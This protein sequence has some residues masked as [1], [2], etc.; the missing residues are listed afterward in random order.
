MISKFIK[1][2]ITAP[3]DYSKSALIIDLQFGCVGLMED[4][5]AAKEY[6]KEMA[7]FINGL[8]EQSIP[9]CWATI[10]DQNKLYKP[11]TN[12]PNQTIR[13][14][15]ELEK[16]GFTKGPKNSEIEQIY[17]EFI[18]EYGPRLNE[19]V[20][21]KTSKSALLEPS[22][23]NK[24]EEY[25]AIL[26]NELYVDAELP[27]IPIDNLASF[28][29]ELGVRDL[30]ISGAVSSHCVTESYI[31][32]T[33]KGINTEIVSDGLLSWKTDQYDGNYLSDFLTCDA[34]LS[35]IRIRSK[36]SD[37]I[38][39][40]AGDREL[41]NADTD[42]IRDISFISLTSFN[43]PNSIFISNTPVINNKEHINNKLVN[44]KP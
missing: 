18:R 27:E 20:Y 33:T 2:E 41:S 35:E 23:L 9:I 1:Q 21:C 16:M 15:D 12:E 37:I 30:I 29:L 5:G 26:K 31:T 43:T 40:E 36:I 42:K 7:S 19:V 6:L 17:L 8:R 3:V 13:S 32:A 44:N 22:D 25:N 10:G 11:I 34:E 14:N 38:T 4:V 28:M 39:G 24:S